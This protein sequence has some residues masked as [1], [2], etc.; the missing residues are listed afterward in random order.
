MLFQML[1][2]F[3]R[4]NNDD[5]TYINGLGQEELEAWYDDIYQLW[6]LAALEIDNF[7]RKKRVTELLGKINT[8]KER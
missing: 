2:R 5:N 6:L 7:E 4:H 3:I 8:P 1:N